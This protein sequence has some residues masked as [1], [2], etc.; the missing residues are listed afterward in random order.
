MEQRPFIIT[1]CARSG[2]VYTAKLLTAAGAPCTHE[3]LFS[4]GQVNRLM[5]KELLT[6]GFT[7][8]TRAPTTKEIQQL[9]FDPPRSGESSW[10]AAALLDELPKE[11]LVFHQLRNPLHVIR[12]LMRRRFFH[13]ERGRGGNYTKYVWRALKEN[14][15]KCRFPIDV[16][17]DPPIVQCMKYWIDWNQLVSH[18]VG[19]KT[20]ME[21]FSYRVEDLSAGKFVFPRMLQMITGS[22]IPRSTNLFDQVPRNTNHRSVDMDAGADAIS[23]ADLPG[24]KVKKVLESVASTWG[25][26]EKDLV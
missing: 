16:D 3:R 25:Y 9:Y 15:G 4:L 26:K 21:C 23:W 20:A 14:Q 13:N 7:I 2:T 5:A 22:W 10:L 1:G 24:G 19:R 8:Y 6:G 18:E 11:V 17:R 12:S